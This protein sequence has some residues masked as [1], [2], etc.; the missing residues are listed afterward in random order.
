MSIARE[1]A[2]R[3]GARIT[4]TED[5]AEAVTG[6][7]FIHTDVWVSMGESAD[8]WTGRVRLLTPYQVNAARWR[9]PATPSTSGL[10]TVAMPIMAPLADFAGA[11]RSLV[12]TAYQSAS[13]LLNL[14]TPT[15]AVVMGGLAIARVPYGK[16]LRFVW[17]VLAILAVLTIIVLALGAL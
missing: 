11:N 14:V 3:T 6:V 2:S 8:V 13:G 10:A 7:D 4:I 1:I 17:P 9:S 5:V 12:V 15:S 16:Y